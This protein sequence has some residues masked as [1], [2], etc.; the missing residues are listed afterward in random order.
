MEYYTGP[1]E[2]VLPYILS[3]GST[4]TK[5]YLQE[6]GDGHLPMFSR[7]AIFSTACKIL[8]LQPKGFHATAVLLVLCVT[9]RR[10][11]SQF[12][13]VASRLVLCHAFAE[14]WF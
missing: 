11:T 8:T 4:P 3:A 5:R 13:P 9:Q 1:G 12:I 14:T 6:Q 2:T 7:V 10:Q